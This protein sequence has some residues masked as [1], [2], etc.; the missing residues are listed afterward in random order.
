M[1]F[2]NTPLM[3]AISRLDEAETTRKEGS[4]NGGA[5]AVLLE[6]HADCR[7]FKDRLVSDL[8]Q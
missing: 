7:S 5:V 3:L 2:G 6:A 8:T 4:P 1:Q